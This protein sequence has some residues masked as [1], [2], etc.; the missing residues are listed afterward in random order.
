M[1]RQEI[2]TMMWDLAFDPVKRGIPTSAER[3]GGRSQ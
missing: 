3:L 1:N 2:I